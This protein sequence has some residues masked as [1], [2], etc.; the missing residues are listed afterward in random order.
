VNPP[1][2]PARA[3][4]ALTILVLGTA[5]C[6]SQSGTPPAASCPSYAYGIAPDDASTLG[7]GTPS[8]AMAAIVE[9]INALWGSAATYCVCDASTLLA[10]CAS[11]AFVTPD[12]YGYVYYDAAFLRDL[13]ALSRGRASAAAWVLAH[14]MGHNIQLRFSRSYTGSLDRELSADCYAG[15]FI[16]AI[17]CHDGLARGDIEAVLGTACMVADPE[18][19]PA[20]DPAAHGDCTQRMNAVQRGMNGYDTIKDPLTVCR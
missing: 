1:S 5:S 2:A 3:W 20:F 17:A 15:Y 13:V 6:D 18:W 4:L 14:E 12:A 11:N 10:G 9:D 7:C 8:T 16:Q 19:V